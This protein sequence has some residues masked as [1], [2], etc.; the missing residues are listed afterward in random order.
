MILSPE[1]FTRR[2]SELDARR[3]G[4]FVADLWNHRGREATFDGRM[5]TLADGDILIPHAGA[6][7]HRPPDDAE[8]G[9]RN[10]AAMVTNEPESVAA[11]ALANRLD[12]DLLTAVDL[13]EMAL[14]GIDREARESL[15]AEY[16][17]RSATAPS[18]SRS[19]P[20]SSGATAGKLLPDRPVALATVVALLVAGFVLGVAVSPPLPGL[21]DGGDGPVYGASGPADAE[22]VTPATVPETTAGTVANT[23]VSTPFGCHNSPKSAAKALVGAFRTNDP[24]TND[25]LRT[26]WRS[27][28]REFRRYSGPFDT[29]TTIMHTHPFRHLL[30]PAQVSYGPPTGSEGVAR[31][32][33]TVLSVEG[34]RFV[35]AFTLQRQ[36]APS[37]AACWRL[38][39]LTYRTNDTAAA[40]DGR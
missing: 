9:L 35:Y 6:A 3:F 34:E 18:A 5:V 25:S 15:F 24:R 8:A 31:Q 26:V 27:S 22:E 21:T 11:A 32:P 19:E 30:D 13:R 12:A 29:F 33:V 37:D 1:E 38:D 7:D 17:E 20:R 23:A 28:S 36:S 2:L 39:G 4:E 14:Y 40:V 16:F 10:V